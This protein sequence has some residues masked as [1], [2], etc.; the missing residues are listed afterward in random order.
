MY[1]FWFS[2]SEF[3]VALC[4]GV[5]FFIFVSPFEIQEW[6]ER[7][8]SSFIYV[9][10]KPYMRWLLMLNET[11]KKVRDLKFPTLFVWQIGLILV[12]PHFASWFIL[13]E[14]NHCKIWATSAVCFLEVKACKTAGKHTR[15]RAYHSRQSERELKKKKKKGWEKQAL[16]SGLWVVLKFSFISGWM[17]E[18]VC[19]KI[20]KKQ[21]NILGYFR[22][23]Q[24][25]I[26]NFF[27]LE[28]R[29]LGALISFPSS[30]WS[31]SA[32]RL[33]PLHSVWNQSGI[34]AVVAHFEGQLIP[35]VQSAG[36]W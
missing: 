4:S 30:R 9:A 28:L 17:T 20:K 3:H 11:T 10:I 2:G 12:V 13:S 26:S 35:S 7:N 36:F 24:R 31:K 1:S 8:N 29:F 25:V 34:S 22:G 23:V 27:F 16:M 19:G 18:K 21:G 32:E 14:M 33:T 15:K 6:K 5:S